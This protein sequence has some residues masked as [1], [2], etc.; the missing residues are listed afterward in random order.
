MQTKFAIARRLMAQGIMV[1]IAKGQV[2]KVLLQIVGGKSVG[3]RFV[4]TKKVS[5][6]KRRLAYSEGLATG[7][8]YV[9]NGA[10]KILLSKKSASLLPVGIK[11]IEGNFKKGDTI[12]IRN[13]EGKKLGY[14]VAQY[15]A[16][17]ASALLGKKG[18]QPLVHYNYLVI[19]A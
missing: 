5:A 15:D 1:H 9:D 13:E 7:S 4:P 19:T 11:K 2:E 8:A 16:E 12:E 6:V 10:E 17:T 3:T 14:G 18:A